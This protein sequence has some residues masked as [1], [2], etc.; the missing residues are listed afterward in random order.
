MARY[1]RIKDVRD[2]M[3]DRS[4][5][6]NDFLGDLEFTDEDIAGAMERAARSFNSLPRAV[7]K[8]QPDRMPLD[9]NIPLIA[10]AEELYKSRLQTLARNM[11]PY[12]AGGVAAN[13]DKDR[14]EGIAMLVKNLH[15][16][17][18]ALATE[19]QFEANELGFYGVAG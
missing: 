15:E 11:M 3:F 14:F 16:E 19:L 17:W 8:W 7:V 5:T 4:V 18:I 9:T 12:E 2:Y 1:C 6:D 13:P 10:T